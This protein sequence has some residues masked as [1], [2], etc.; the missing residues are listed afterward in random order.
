MRGDALL[1]L[2]GTRL[3]VID[4]VVPEAEA[5]TK[6]ERFLSSMKITK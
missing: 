2:V 6:S 3:Y 1:V 4:G 5:E